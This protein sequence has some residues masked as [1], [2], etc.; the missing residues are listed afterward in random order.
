MDWLKRIGFFSMAAWVISSCSINPPAVVA[1]EN[2]QTATN[3]ISLESITDEMDDMGNVVLNSFS[4][5]GLASEGRIEA[6]SDDRFACPDVTI[7][8]SNVSPDRTSGSVAITFPE[9]GCTDG[10]KTNVRQGTINISWSGGKWYTVGSTHTFTFNNFRLNGIAITG[11]R[12]LTCTVFTFASSKIWNATWKISGKHTLNWPDGSS[13]TFD[14]NKT[15]VWSHGGAGDLYRYTN[16]PDGD[17]SVK[18]SNRHGKNFTVTIQETL[19][20]TRT[21]KKISKSYLPIYGTQIIV[22]R[23]NGDKLLYIDFG[24]YACDAAYQLTVDGVK[25]VLYGKNDSSND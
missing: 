25:S 10:I 3:V 14:V 8:F 9:S 7:V 23:S 16:G 6:L 1:D 18:G 17:F 21:C 19:L 2:R 5:S 4:D 13:A 22:D 20:Y 12:T 11:T 24:S 15:K